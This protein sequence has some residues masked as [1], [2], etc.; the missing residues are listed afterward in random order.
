MVYGKAMAHRH[1][2][3]ELPTVA[4]LFTDMNATVSQKS[5]Q[6]SSRPHA[7]VSLLT[8]HAM[9]YI[10]HDPHQHQETCA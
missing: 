5:W 10:S 2:D 7:R 4:A 6:F 3:V 1:V 8:R 9:L